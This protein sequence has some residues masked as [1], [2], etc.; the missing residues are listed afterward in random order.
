MTLAEQFIF[1]TSEMEI[2][3]EGNVI[4]AKNGKAVSADKDLEIEAKN[5]EY[6]KDL[7]LLK[8]FDGI[9]HI[10]SDNLKIEFNSIELDQ[11]N[12]LD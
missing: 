5:F 7:N 6:I 9:A 12:N 3:D 2:S 4:L 10:K 11:K 8:A 1:Q